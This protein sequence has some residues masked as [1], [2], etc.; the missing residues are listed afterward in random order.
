MARRAFFVRR[1]RGSSGSRTAWV[2]AILQSVLS[3]GEVQIVRPL[4]ENRIG[5]QML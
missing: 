1:R 5:F 4:S 3:L 2:A